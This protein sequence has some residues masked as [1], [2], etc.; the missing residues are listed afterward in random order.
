MARSDIGVVRLFYEPH[1]EV[2]MRGMGGVGLQTCYHGHEGVRDL[3]ADLDEAFGNW[4]WR[5]RAIADGGDRLAVHA[6]FVGYGRTSGAKTA[7]ND[8]GTAV[9]LSPQGLVVRQDW[10]VEQGGWAKALE[11]VGLSE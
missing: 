6:D 10:F 9:R 2:W 3:Y 1:A 11:A 7:L 4:S 5:I 8:G